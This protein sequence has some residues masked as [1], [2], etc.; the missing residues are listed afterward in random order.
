MSSDLIP[1]PTRETGH[2]GGSG[3]FGWGG[4]AD[5]FE[6]T[7]ELAW[8]QSTLIYSRMLRNS[9]V[10]ASL[11]AVLLPI[12]SA[13]WRI[14][15]AGASE[16]VVR[17]VADDLGLPV[18][19]ENPAAAP[20]TRDRFSWAEHLRLAAKHSLAYGHMFFEQVARLD[21]AGRFRLRKLAPRFPPS[22]A[23][24]QVARDGGLVSITQ[25]PGPGDRGPVRPIPVRFLV[26]YV[27]EK[28]G[29]SWV[30]QALPLD[31]P[32]ASPDG[33]T[34][35]GDLTVGS[36]L[37]DETGKVRHVVA[38]S[39]VW[40]SRPCYRVRFSD[41]SSI[42]ADAN[43]LWES[44]TW[45]ARHNGGSPSL[46]TTAE[47]ADT[48]YYDTRR[49]AG[50]N[51]AV[52]KTA[53]LQY[54]RQDLLIDPYVLGA[55]L[56]DGDALHPL[57]TAAVW[58]AADTAAQIEFCGYPTKLRHN[59][60]AGSNGRIIY[61]YGGLATQLRVLGLVGDKHIPDGYLRSSYDQRMALLQGLMDTDGST[62][63]G[64]CEFSNT[65]KNLVDGVAD[66]VRSLGCHVSV[67]KVTRD[68][69]GELMPGGRAPA[70]LSPVW[71][72]H[73][74]PTYTPFRLP[75]KV[76]KFEAGDRRQR[77]KTKGR[78]LGPRKWR[79]VRAVEPVGS[80]D[81]V[82]IE[83]DSP[84]HLFL[85]GR[86]LI[87]T[88]NSLLRPAYRDWFLADRLVAMNAVVMERNGMGIPTVE[89]TEHARYDTAAETR[90]E[91]IATRLRVGETA[92]ARMPYGFRLRLVGVEGSTPDILRSV[93]YH[94]TQVAKSV[95][96][97]FIQL[98]VSSSYGSRSLA[99]STIDFFQLAVD[100]HAQ[101]LADVAN[102]HVVRD[103]VDWNWGAA[104]P[105]PLLVVDT[106]AAQLEPAI[107]QSVT[108][109]VRVGAVTP[110]DPLEQFLRSAMKLPARQ[111][112]DPEDVDA[113]VEQAR[114]VDVA[115]LQQRAEAVGAFIRAGF[116]PQDSLARSGLESMRHSGLVPVKP[117]EDPAPAAVRLAAGDTPPDP[118]RQP[119]RVEL[120]AQVDFA[121][122]DGRWRSTLDRLLAV[123]VA[124]RT[125][126]TADLAEQI[127]GTGSPADLT[128]VTVTA[129][130]VSGLL[131]GDLSAAAAAAVE[132]AAAEAARQGVTDAGLHDVALDRLA[133]RAADLTARADV[134]ATL[135]VEGYR[136]SAIGK[137]ATVAAGSDRYDPDLVADQ[138]REHLEGL[139]DVN[140]RDQ[141][142]GAVTAAENAG[143]VAYAETADP[144]AVYSSELLDG[145][146]CSSCETI[147]GTRFPTLDAARAAYPA[148]GF[149]GCLGGVRCRGTLVF[150][151]RSED[152]PAVDS[153]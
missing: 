24:I 93:E 80:Q 96:A 34:T 87:P 35:M 16:P 131:T 101:Q 4:P 89:Q 45:A 128:A 115:D 83:V 100:A 113:G 107:A 99:E 98:G 18:V 137:A 95:L 90:A 7:V 134:A 114:K 127:A 63:E 132:D 123:W 103:L 70:H 62:S 121:A 72:V 26:G 143:R 150:I 64:R 61:I 81:T 124:V 46:V 11:Q 109:L 153:V 56:G 104:E 6:T 119:N 148:G 67:Q 31:T 111:L 78:K 58:D 146:T 122:L 97:Q 36:R 84:S 39:E 32:I 25:H 85:A 145:R 118:R 141:L 21:D 14:D 108:E 77:G 2:P 17:L 10:G 55:W 30:G 53:P 86:A 59:G 112:A 5:P 120:A 88:H 79:T 54:Q 15:P 9:Q 152:V 37:F 12:L 117:V 65:N 19:G 52:V 28:E 75:R 149:T 138:V 91:E 133:G 140:A 41:G 125:A 135:T 94:D 23:D 57:V 76:E 126:V 20:R 66:L 48:L 33:W 102:D 73:F 74:A 44:H 142:G 47:M 42:V 116:D 92:G 51:H 27:H 40:K 130:G 68:R 110:D 151:H 147:D 82:C 136:Q 105:A 43:H 29:S 38:K 50:C 22:V 144:A 60:P 139:A 8:P 106:S 49:N 129:A 3:W 13:P 71:R 69:S 1:A